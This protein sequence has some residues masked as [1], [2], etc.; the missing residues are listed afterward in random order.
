[1]CQFINSKIY[2]PAAVGPSKVSI[3]FTEKDHRLRKNT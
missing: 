2:K 3:L 1:M